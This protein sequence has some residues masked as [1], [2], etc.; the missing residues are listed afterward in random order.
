[1]IKICANSECSKEFKTDDSRRKFCSLSC[2]AKV[3][4]RGVRRH[5]KAPGYCALCGNPKTRH[6]S[7]WCSNK[8][9]QA[10]VAS[11]RIA[12]WLS[13]EWSGCCEYT[14]ELSS[15]IRAYLL[16]QANNKCGSC[17]WGIE[18]KYTGVVPLQIHHV[19]GNY[20][21]NSPGN[22]VVLCPNCHSLTDN[23]GSRQSKYKG[24]SKRRH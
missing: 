12:S 20:K 19:D 18:N 21:N 9:H 1:M 23:F 24:N 15:T 22:L 2:S 10:Y 3:N 5:G 16:K 11:V 7:N 4:N 13:G 17:G 6:K 14:G 8:C